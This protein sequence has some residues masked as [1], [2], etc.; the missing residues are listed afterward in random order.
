MT[1][2]SESQQRWRFAAAGS[3]LM[4]VAAT[5][6]LCIL[7][8][9]DQ[10]QAQEQR[11]RRQKARLEH[12]HRD[13]SGYIQ[14]LQ[15]GDIKTLLRFTPASVV[16]KSGGEEAMRELLASLYLDVRGVL[17]RAI[18]RDQLAPLEVLPIEPLPQDRERLL[19]RVQV[20]GL[21]GCWDGTSLARSLSL[22]A[23]SEDEGRSWQFLCTRGLSR[24]QLK[25]F[26][27]DAPEVWGLPVDG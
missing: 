23:L 6:A 3:I 14:A 12:F 11:Q 17:D 13:A 10:L 22:V 16:R 25:V 27:P 18:A 8:R 7:D 15:V 26:F 20:K 1:D 9:V 24:K 4:L 2:V 19:V 21:L 5:A